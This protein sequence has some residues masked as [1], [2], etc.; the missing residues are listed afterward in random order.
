MTFDLT[1]DANEFRNYLCSRI[2]QYANLARA[3]PVKLLEVGFQFDQGGAIVV[4]FDCRPNAQTDGTW[5]MRY[6]GNTLDRLH[7]PNLTERVFESSVTFIKLDG[8][9]RT[10]P[11]DCSKS[12]NLEQEMASLLGEMLRDSMIAA[13]ASH[14]LDLLPKA[15]GF[16]IGIEELNGNYGWLSDA[17]T[18]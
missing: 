8:A 3:L 10:L 13:I 9:S 16:M 17:T 12:A 11:N 18:L 4:H 7:W 14:E 2:S 1:N 15:P 6:Q 5:T